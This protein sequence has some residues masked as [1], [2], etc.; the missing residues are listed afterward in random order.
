MCY[1]LYKQL[2]IERITLFLYVQIDLHILLLMILVLLSQ[3][4]MLSLLQQLECNIN[5]D[6]S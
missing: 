6:V 3:S 4:V 1:V 2:T 5:N